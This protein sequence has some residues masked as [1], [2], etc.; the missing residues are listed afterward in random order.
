MAKIRKIFETSIP[1]NFISSQENFN[2][3]WKSFFKSELGQIHQSLPWDEMVK[4]FKI[5]NKKTG[6]KSFFSPQGKLALQFLKSYTNLSDRK[7]YERL[8]ADYQFQFFCGLHIPPNH[9]LCNYK[10]ISDIRVEL[11]KNLN[12]NNVQK[13]LAKAWKPY[14]KNP[15]IIMEDATCYETQMRRPSDVKLLWESNAWIY[16][17]IKLINKIL[18]GRMPRSKFYEQQNKYLNYSRKRKKSYKKT[19]KRTKS[20]IYLLNKLLGQL[21]EIEQGL[22]SKYVFPKQY[23]QRVLIITK[24]LEQQQKLYIGEKVKNRIVSISKSYIRPIVRG[25]ESKPVEF[26]AKAN[27]LQIDGINFIEHISFDAFN[28]GTRLIPSV[29]MAQSLFRKKVRMLSADKIYATNANR[30]YCRLKNIITNFVRK[31]RAGKHEPELKQIRKILNIER[32]T[33]ME[34]AFG[35]QKNHYSLGK[36]KARTNKTELLWIF[37]GIHTANAVQIAKR[38]NAEKTYSLAA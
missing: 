17:Q 30:K 28:E 15:E 36:I 13:I 37:F 10:I 38:Q 6:R 23:Y 32:A 11:S 27:L 33:R 14:I 22:P 3:Y 4:A 12:I 20:L 9:R 2:L 18:K 7:L 35:T 29:L 19:H 16:S 5:R 8:N 1:F 31:G 34:G 24:I 25:K 21:R 26:G